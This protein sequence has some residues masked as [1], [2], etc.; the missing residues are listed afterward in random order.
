MYMYNKGQWTLCRALGGSLIAS[1]WVRFSKSNQLSMTM[2][3][4]HGEVYNHSPS[5]IL[6]IPLCICIIKTNGHYQHHC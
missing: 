1:D 4:Q 3:H 5:Y 2:Y 6:V